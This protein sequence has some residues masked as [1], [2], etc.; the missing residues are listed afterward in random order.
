[1][2]K[3]KLLVSTLTLMVIA[4][5][6]NI[7]N[8]ADTIGVANYKKIESEYNY[9]K[10]VYKDLDNKIVDLQQFVIDKD[11]EFKAIESPIQKKNFEEK[12]QKEYKAKED[13][14]ITLKA[15]KEDEIFNNIMS[16]TNAVAKTRKIDVVLDYRVI[17]TGGIDISD[18]VIQYL[19]TR[20]NPS[21]K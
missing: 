14:I 15:K 19:N 10:K 16:A 11:K 1:M 8:A 21:K 13:A 2:N 20:P 4:S 18:D 7:A 12:T 5:M 3:I 9:A 17:F 6:S